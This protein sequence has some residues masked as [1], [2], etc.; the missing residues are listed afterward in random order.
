MAAANPNADLAGFEELD[1]PFTHAAI[2]HRVF[3]TGDGPPVLVLHELPG[4]SPA[5]L[6]FGRRL[7]ARGF[8]VY[9]PLLFGE[10][11][12]DDWRGSHRALCVSQEFARLQAG[13]SAPILDWLRALASDLSAR[14]EHANVGAIGMCLTGAFVIPLVLERCVTAPVAA[15]PGVPFSGVFRAVG[16]GRG[17]WMTQLNVSE[18]DVQQAVVRVQ[19]DG[20]TLLAGRFEKDRI[21]PAERLDRL[22]A[23][24]GDRLIRRELPGGSAF[25]PPHATLTTK[26]EQAPDNPDE[27]TRRWFEEVVGFLRDRLQRP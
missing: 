21:C 27:P 7:A 3:W 15:Q 20:L 1:P 10:P 13:V 6:R 23:Q 24:F 9:L 25:D 8:R 22:Q 11:G 5:A 18:A 17:D 19:R 26:Y 14:H 12:Q 2:T 16:L 4:L